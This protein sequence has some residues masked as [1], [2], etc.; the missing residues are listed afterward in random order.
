[1]ENKKNILDYL[2]HTFVIFG[3]TVAVLSV[4]T[5][6]L[7]EDAQ[8]VSTMF[9]L[10]RDGI[11]L[12]TLL[13]YLLICACI[14]LLRFL[15]FTDALLKRGSVTLRTILM[16]TSVILLT[17]L[18][19]YLFGWFPVHSYGKN[20]VLKGISLRIEKG[21]VI[22]L[23]GPSGAGKTTLVNLLTGQITPTSG[24]I[25]CNP[26]TLTSGIMMDSFGLYSRL[27]VWDNLAIF[28]DIYGVSRDRIPA[29][30]KRAGLAQAGIPRSR[31][32]KPYFYP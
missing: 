22:G 4:I 10:G 8:N 9:A 27:S 19:A 2:T 15:L 23:L 28:A 20:E 3:V 18:F 16:V 1:M 13:Q 21:T 5:A 32:L 6:I 25:R 11:P 31:I 26:D 29:L 12:Y 7:G 14:T 17:G 24:S 30:L